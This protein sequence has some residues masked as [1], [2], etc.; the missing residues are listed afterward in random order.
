LAAKLRLLRRS[1]E[2]TIEKAHSIDRTVQTFHREHP[3][4]YYKVLVF[5]LLA[6]AVNFLTLAYLLHLFDD[7]GVAVALRVYAGINLATFITLV[8][9]NRIGVDEGAGY[10]LF[11][12]LGLEPTL[13]IL[14]QFVIRLKNTV[15]T[16]IAMPLALLSGRNNKKLD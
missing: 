16:G 3:G 10:F 4:A 5:Q 11:S 13:G 8:F 9:P 1:P 2:E 15:I 14:I 6:R 7:Q 12:F